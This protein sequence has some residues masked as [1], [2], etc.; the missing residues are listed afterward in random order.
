[1]RIVHFSDWHGHPRELPEADVYVCT[2]DMYP[3][4]PT[5]IE[6]PSPH[7]Y[8]GP[9]FYQGILRSHEVAQQ[10]EWASRFAAAGGMRACMK[11]PDAPVLLVP[12]NHDFIPLAGM[13]V[14]CEVVHEFEDNELV[15]IDGITF[16]GHVGIPYIYGGWNHEVHK[17]ELL[18]RVRG[19]PKAH[20]FLTHYA[21]GGILDYEWKSDRRVEF[22][23]SGMVPILW[24]KGHESPLSEEL[25]F[26]DQPL[27]YEEDMFR[28]L[29]CFGHIHG[30]GGNVVDHSGFRFS[31]A[32]TTINVIDF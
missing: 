17:D 9:T 23:L 18:D 20:V 10:T 19:M 31:N 26:S 30:S 16:T 32:A 24:S 2:G 7:P 11:S 5:T 14:G 15:E 12:G 13:F 8:H 3:N 25:E 4:F 6:E 21:P 27:A 29:H 28:A 1:M 22:G